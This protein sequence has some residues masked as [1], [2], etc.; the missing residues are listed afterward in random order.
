MSGP[1]NSQLGVQSQLPATAAA[2]PAQ[3]CI[4]GILLWLYLSSRRSTASFLA[5]NN[6]NDRDDNMKKSSA[7]TSVDGTA[8]KSDMGN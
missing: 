8:A 4:V 1:F 2:R 3:V 6:I 5:Y 7:F